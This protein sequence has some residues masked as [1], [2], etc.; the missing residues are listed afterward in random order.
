MTTG[1][2]ELRILIADD[3]RL[4]REGLR[5][6]LE[7]RPGLHVVG[8]AATGREALKLAAETDPH[9]ILLDLEMPKLSGLEVLRQ[10]HIADGEP[11]VV[12]MTAVIEPEQ[13]REAFLLGTRGV[14]LKESA[15]T[16]LF[17]CIEA[18][19]AGKYWIGREAVSDLSR[20]LDK[21][22]QLLAPQ[23][24]PKDFGLTP[25][26]LEILAAIVAGKTN[27]ELADQFAISEQTV[28]HHIT[29]IF[30]KMGVYNRLELALFAIHHGLVRKSEPDS[31]DIAHGTKV[32][33]S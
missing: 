17:S 4:F 9:L 33:R 10:M 26:E 28:K 24:R 29:H 2:S 20:L 15:T 13:I 21:T 6:L 30:D 23:P 16:L 8:E 11:R 5:A 31:A 18:V 25:R 19:R 1:K 7:E 14:I 12:V 32:L 3:H 22:Q 27:R